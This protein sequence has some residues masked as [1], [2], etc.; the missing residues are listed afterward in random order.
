RPVV[1][2]PCAARGAGDSAPRGLE[3]A[4]A[5]ARG[6][7][8]PGS[9]AINV[10][11]APAALVLVAMI[12]LAA[13]AGRRIENGIYHSPKGYRVALPSPPWVVAEASRADLELRH[14]GGGAAML[15]NA[16]CDE[17]STARS[18]DLLLRQLLIGIR[19]RATI[20]REE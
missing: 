19:D 1:P 17:R 10:C 7:D 15:A 3:R 18:G 20:T 16:E 9:V 5:T 4:G 14:H 11:R 6:T 8:H 2:H 12:A 13:C